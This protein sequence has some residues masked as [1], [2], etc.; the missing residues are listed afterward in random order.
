M[1]A[2]VL[3]ACGVG[4]KVRRTCALRDTA[5]TQQGT[6]VRAYPSV[7]GHLMRKNL[8]HP[9][10]VRKRYGRSGQKWRDGSGETEVIMGRRRGRCGREDKGH[11]EGDSVCVR[12]KSGSRRSSLKRRDE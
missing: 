7:L 6:T 10:G 5:R 9:S 12:N 8:D 1:R 4:T 2:C 3:D 11:E